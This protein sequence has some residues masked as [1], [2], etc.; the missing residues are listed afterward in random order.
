MSLIYSYA[1]FTF[2]IIISTEHPSHLEQKLVPVETK[3]YSVIVIVLIAIYVKP[4]I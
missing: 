2:P 3:L 4:S 1:Y